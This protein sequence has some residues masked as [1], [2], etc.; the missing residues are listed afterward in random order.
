MCLNTWS[1][2]QIE[3]SISEFDVLP[4]DQL[5]KGAC[6]VNEDQSAARLA[7]CENLDADRS[8]RPAACGEVSFS[9]VDAFWSPIGKS[10][11]RTL[12][13]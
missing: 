7:G 6:G 2:A 3:R 8:F 12:M 9:S 13:R 11:S 1:G 4:D 5:V 10:S